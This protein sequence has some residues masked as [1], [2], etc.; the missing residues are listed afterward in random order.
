MV[1][2]DID[3]VSLKQNYRFKSNDFK[4]SSWPLEEQEEGLKAESKKRFAT[5]AIFE[6]TI[7]ARCPGI[8][9]LLLFYLFVS[10]KQIY[11]GSVGTWL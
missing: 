5:E 8:T 10:C 3:L 4:K 7:S 9:L 6:L 1:W 2:L 11:F